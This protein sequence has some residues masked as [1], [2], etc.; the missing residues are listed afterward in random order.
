[1]LTFKFNKMRNIFLKRFLLFAFVA[2]VGSSCNDLLDVKSD[3]L[4]TK[5]NFYTSES[6]FQAA[7]APLYN[8]VW[9]DFNN[10]FYFGLGDGRSYN[11]YAPF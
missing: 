8:I 4:I 11:L 1:M 9:F 6:D 7:T 3:N 2:T 10:N 5:D